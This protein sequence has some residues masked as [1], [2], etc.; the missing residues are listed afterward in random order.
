MLP[1]FVKV[2]QG[3]GW[4]EAELACLRLSWSVFMALLLG[5]VEV[6]LTSSE[7]IQF[8]AYLSLS[9]RGQD[10]ESETLSPVCSHQLY[11]FHSQAIFFDK[12][13]FASEMLNSLMSD[14]YV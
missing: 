11:S 10:M 9:L 1:I 6:S 12:S 5:F 4:R 2:G 7:R 8:L 3:F 13:L 14:G